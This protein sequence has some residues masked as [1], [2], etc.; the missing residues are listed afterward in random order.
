MKIV[1]QVSA[2][3]AAR[4]PQRLF[5][6]AAEGEQ[7]FVIVN[8]DLPATAVLSMAELT[9]LQDDLELM[10]VLLV[11]AVADS[12]KRYSTTDVMARFGYTDADLDSAS[13][14]CC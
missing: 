13:E 2:D 4:D 14:A 12:N 10:S 5:R 1:E 11:R 3:D 7:R 8:A 6:E 9:E